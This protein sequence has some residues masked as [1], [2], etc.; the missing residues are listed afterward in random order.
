M[1]VEIRYQLRTHE[2]ARTKIFT[3]KICVR[4]L[5]ISKMNSGFRYNSTYDLGLKKTID[6][7]SRFL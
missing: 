2:R 4:E 5:V 6:F 1:T 3:V 7:F